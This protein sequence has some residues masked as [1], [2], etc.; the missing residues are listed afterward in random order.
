M[1]MAI[2]PKPSQ[3]IEDKPDVSKMYLSTLFFK[4]KSLNFSENMGISDTSKKQK[5]GTN[6]KSS[7]WF[8]NMLKS[9]LLSPL[10][11]TKPKEAK[12]SPV[13]VVVKPIKLSD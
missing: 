10:L 12:N 1:V 8:C 4:E 5:T 11:K 6:D 2:P 7:H 13:A 9:Q 3:M